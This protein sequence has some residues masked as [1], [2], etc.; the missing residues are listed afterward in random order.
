MDKEKPKPRVRRT[1]PDTNPKKVD[2]HELLEKFTSSML[3]FIDAVKDIRENTRAMLEQN[4][5][6]KANPHDE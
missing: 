4:H 5:S 1:K 3:Q 2:P 6:K